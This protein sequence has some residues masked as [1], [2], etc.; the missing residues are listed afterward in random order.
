MNFYLAS[1]AL[2]AF[3]DTYFHKVKGRETQQ[4]T[5]PF[6]TTEDNAGLTEHCIIH[7]WEA[8]LFWL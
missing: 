1:W 2:F 3:G 4:I 5:Q 6:N 8:I 7:A